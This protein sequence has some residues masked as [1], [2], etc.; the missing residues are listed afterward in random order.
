MS[1][2]AYLFP[3][4][5]SQ[6]IGM[7]ADLCELGN[8]IQEHLSWASEVI[9][10]DLSSIVASGPEERLNQT[11]FTQPAI[12]AT[13]IGLFSMTRRLGLDMPY[14]AAGH[15][16]GEYSASVASGMLNFESAVQLVHER[17]KIMQ[18]ATPV[19]SGAMVVVLG[20]SDETVR[21]VCDLAE[22][23][24]EIA[25]FNCPGQVVIAGLT[26]DVQRA[27]VACKDAGAR[28]IAPIPMSVPSH[29]SLLHNAEKQLEEVLSQ[30]EF[31]HSN[32]EVYQNINAQISDDL[33]E[34]KQNLVRQISSSVLW[35]QSIRA[36][37]NDGVD[38]F[39]ECGPGRVLTGLTRRIDREVSAMALSNLETFKELI[40]A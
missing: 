11:E 3:G 18:T 12:L 16:L 7:L 6:S 39:I 19:G 26:S 32:F 37:I 13:S 38:T 23:E 25:N 10:V 20:L 40:R 24:V 29:C 36:M 14:A 15:S 27:S 5:G 22:G 17:G 9:S 28:R 35:H 2:I 8:D 1:S 31:Q 33:G 34:F 4:Q 21:Q 30:L